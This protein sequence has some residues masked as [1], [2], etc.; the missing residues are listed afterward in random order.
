MKV[1]E[2]K[3]GTKFVDILGDTRIITDIRD[4]FYICKWIN[5]DGT[6]SKGEEW[7]VLSHFTKWDKVIA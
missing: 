2:F 1:S 3:V 7:R 5:N 4:G 6:Y